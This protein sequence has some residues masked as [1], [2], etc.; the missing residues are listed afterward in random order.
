MIYPSETPQEMEAALGARL[1]QLRLS[2]G[3]D[4]I[5]L[6]GRAGISEKALRNLEGGEG[7]TLKTLL[8]V[9]RAL[10]REDWLKTIAPIAT[11]NPLHL[12]REARPRQRA[13]RKTP[14]KKT[15]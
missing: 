11:I 9:I 7:S 12:T 15:P 2:K 1:K 8:S 4:Q 3:L 13:P 6:A 14:P 5:T 10:G